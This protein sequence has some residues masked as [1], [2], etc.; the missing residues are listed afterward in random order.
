LLTVKH[1]SLLIFVVP[2]HNMV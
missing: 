1:Y 2:V